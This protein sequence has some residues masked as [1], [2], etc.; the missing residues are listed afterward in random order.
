MAT[1][2]ITGAARGLGLELTRQLLELP[3]AQVSMVFTITRSEPQAGLYDLIRNSHGRVK[4]I[5]ATVNDTES[6]EEAARQV[7]GHLGSRR[8]LDVLVNNAGILGE[9][10]PDGRIEN[11]S[12]DE[13]ALVLDTNLIGPHRVTRAFLPLLREGQQ[14]K[15]IN[16]CVYNLYKNFHQPVISI[17]MSIVWVCSLTIDSARSSTMGAFS[18]AERL[19]ANPA[20]A[21]KISKT[22]L[23]MLHKIMSLDLADEGFIFLSISPGVSNHLL[24]T[25]I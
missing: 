2:L 19:H 16:M 4:N 17:Y 15:V 10:H 13:L 22:A 21:Y 18:W 3:E 11:C 1:Y 7:R 6:I 9:N 5:L 14:K 25:R 8:G 12:P 24:P 23:N 20:H